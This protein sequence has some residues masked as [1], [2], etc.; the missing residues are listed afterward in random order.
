MTS[1]GLGLKLHVHLVVGLRLRV[2]RN[3][4]LDSSLELGVL[5]LRV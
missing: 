5:D 3:I 1:K 2:L 4:A